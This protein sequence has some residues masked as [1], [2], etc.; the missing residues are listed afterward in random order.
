M[1]GCDAADDWPI[2]VTAGGV[3]GALVTG[4]G[5]GNVTSA[6]TG[7]ATGAGDGGAGA[8]DGLG[9]GGGGALTRA[10]GAGV[11]TGAEEGAEVDFITVAAC[12]FAAFAP[13]VTAL[14]AGLET[15]GAGA[16]TF[17]T[18]GLL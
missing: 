4:G 11:V 12:G 15:V 9:G 5:G 6:L 13:V 16:A 18:A 10:T 8:S 7:A 2:G 3:A 1:G 17:A 14:A